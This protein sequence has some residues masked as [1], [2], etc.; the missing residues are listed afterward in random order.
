MIINNI[1]IHA[2]YETNDDHKN[3]I[4]CDCLT[5]LKDLPNIE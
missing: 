4:V 2:E 1:I 5:V 3:F